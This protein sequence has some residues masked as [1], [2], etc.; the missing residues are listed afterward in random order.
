MRL[1]A[2]T[3]L[4]CLTGGAVRA[5]SPA[6]PEVWMNHVRLEGLAR[7]GAK[8]DYVQRHLGALEFPINAVG[9]LISDDDLQRLAAIV[10]ARRIRVAI[11]CGYFDWVSKLED[12]E[13]PSPK[14]MTDT[15]RLRV[16]PGVGEETARFE[17][18]K[19]RP[20]VRAGVVPDY[21]NL[22]GPIR[23]MLWPG[24]DVGRNDLQG[25]PAIDASVD[26]L[27]AYMRAMRRA[28]P[29]VQFFALVNFPNWGWKGEPSYWGGMFYGDYYEALKRIDQ[30]TRAAHIPILGVTADN[31]YEYYAG[32]QP[33]KPWMTLPGEARPTKALD[34]A[35]IDWRK[36]LLDLERAV[37][38]RGL[39]FNL[40]V[41]SQ[42]G[43]EASGEAFHR[44]TL[45]YLD[46][47]RKDGGA[48]RRCI[49]QSWYRFPEKVASEDEAYTMTNLVKEAIRR[50]EGESGRP[51]AMGDKP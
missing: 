13:K 38:S 32:L 6:R 34:V 37:K 10:K 41:N 40:I 7:S 17:I 5:L 50:I 22:D 12:L 16:E 31:P 24:S 51:A 29:K 18:A 43:G 49:L 48:P 19:L 26:E 42:G 1:L 4:V 21:L 36:R 23:R 14:G 20:L 3:V 39:E 46:A 44:T 9:F 15:P 27:V 2:F 25:L 35:K 11:E 45:A 30:K 8:W 33:H 47:Y 28:Y